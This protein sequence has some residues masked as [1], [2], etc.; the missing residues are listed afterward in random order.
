MGANMK[1]SQIA[2]SGSTRKRYSYSSDVI[3]RRGCKKKVNVTKMSS[4]TYAVKNRE[5]RRRY[6]VDYDKVKKVNPKGMK[7]REVAEQAILRF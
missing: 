6:G 3:A 7:A 5:C 1:L 4:V 2:V